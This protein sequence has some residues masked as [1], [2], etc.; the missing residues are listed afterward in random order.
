M[1]FRCTEAKASEP[2]LLRWRDKKRIV[3]EAI[4]PCRAVVY[5]HETTC[6][7]IELDGPGGMDPRERDGSGYFV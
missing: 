7:I 3:D 5:C 4:V 1:A 2:M 6:R